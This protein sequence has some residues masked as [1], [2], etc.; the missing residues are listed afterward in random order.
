MVVSPKNNRSAKL[1]G[2]HGSVHRQCDFPSTDIIRVKDAGLTPNDKVILTCLLYPPQIIVNL[3]L[4]IVRCAVTHLHQDISCD[5]VGSSKISWIATGAHPPV[6]PESII[7]TKRPHDVFNI[8][9]VPKRPIFIDNISADA[10][11]LKEEGVSIVPEIHPALCH[12][13]DRFC[14]PAKCRLDF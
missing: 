1:T 13:I 7:E 10:R 4:Y 5:G 11:C 2:G 9:G 14:V 3:L 12:G 6:R 8:G